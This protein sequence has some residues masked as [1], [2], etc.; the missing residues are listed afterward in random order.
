MDLGL[1]K[2]TD[3]ERRAATITVGGLITLASKAMALVSAR[4]V[5]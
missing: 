2:I 3:L 4:L 1:T 5:A